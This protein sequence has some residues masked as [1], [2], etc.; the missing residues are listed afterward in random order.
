[1][2]PHVSYSKTCIEVDAMDERDFLY[3]LLKYAL[4]DEA[5][6]LPCESCCQGIVSLAVGCKSDAMNTRQIL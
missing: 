2:G 3:L 6:D 5:Y 4:L 1:M